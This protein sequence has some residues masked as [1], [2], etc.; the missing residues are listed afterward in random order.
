MKMHEATDLVALTDLVAHGP[1]E[2]PGGR[3]P[4]QLA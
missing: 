2:T 4:P 1:L 3:S